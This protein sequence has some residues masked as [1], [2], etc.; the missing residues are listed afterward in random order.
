M[1]YSREDFAA[2]V[3]G[4]TVTSPNDHQAKE[5]DF[6]S[7]SVVF[8]ETFAEAEAFDGIDYIERFANEGQP[9]VKDEI[10]SYIL[11]NIHGLVKQ[12]DSSLK[13]FERIKVNP[14]QTA[15]EPHIYMHVIYDNQGHVYRYIGQAGRLRKQ[16]NDHLDPNSRMKDFW[17]ILASVPLQTGNGY[18]ELLRAWMLNLTEHVC[19]KLF[20]SLVSE[21]TEGWQ[22]VPLNMAPPLYQGNRCFVWHNTSGPTRVRRLIDSLFNSVEKAGKFNKSDDRYF[23]T[24]SKVVIK[25]NW[26]DQ[27]TLGLDADHLDVTVQAFLSPNGPDMHHYAT[28]AHPDDPAARLSFRVTGPS[29]Q[30]KWAKQGGDMMA[31]KMNTFVHLR[32]GKSRADILDMERCFQRVSNTNGLKSFYT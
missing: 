4:T 16:L 30:I 19:T 7:L 27:A 9:A 13:G 12:G 5:S 6:P 21:R 8:Q 10:T 24:F 17:V 26:R 11:P 18:S 20:Q 23:I 22:H 29:G 25:F 2:T 14:H 31:K 32:E 28:A 15:N 3:A 1:S